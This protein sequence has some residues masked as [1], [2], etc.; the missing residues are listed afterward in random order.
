MTLTSESA[1]GFYYWFDANYFKKYV[2]DLPEIF[3]IGSLSG[4]DDCCEMGL[5][6]L[7]GPIFAYSI[8]T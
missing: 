8:Y 4:V 5:R 6:S 7:K 1:S 3:R 2:T